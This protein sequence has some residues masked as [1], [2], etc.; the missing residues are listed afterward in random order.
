MTR[1]A[2][3]LGA[4]AIPAVLAAQEPTR[5]DTT[6]RRSSEPVFLTADSVAKLRAAADSSNRIRAAAVADSITRARVA[7][8]ADSSA[9]VRA[10]AVAQPDSSAVRRVDSSLVRAATP[11]PATPVAPVT[12]PA[13]V[14][15]QPDTTTERDSVATELSYTP[16]AQAGSV[17][18]ASTTTRRGTLNRGM[19]RGP[20]G[21]IF[22]RPA[23][24]GAV[25][26]VAMNDST[27]PEQAQAAPV[28]GVVREESAGEVAPA[29][30][31]S[32]R[33]A[34]ADMSR[35]DIRELQGAMT[36]AGCAVGSIDGVVGPRTRRALECVKRKY[37][38]TNTE[39][40][41]VLEALN[42]RLTSDME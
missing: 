36:D 34:W 37:E 3:I 9:R 13:A 6:V 24:D 1:F 19:T 28:S 15:S 39:L 21:R 10:A 40:T 18:L 16:P 8:Q 30:S 29:L 35:A 27:A 41:P 14:A 12:Q 23:P 20:D 26:M 32:V 42:L 33:T 7:A 38:I 31:T 22:L 17:W 11:V 2:I 25:W 4:L 5:R